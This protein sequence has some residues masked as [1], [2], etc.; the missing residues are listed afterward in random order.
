MMKRIFA[1]SAVA[2]LIVFGAYAQNIG[3]FKDR[4][5]GKVYKI[6]KIGSQV[7]MAENLNFAAE[8][9]KCYE[10]KNANCA[11][12]GRLYDDVLDALKACP[13]GFHLPDD[14]EWTALIDYA[15]GEKK[16]GKKLKS[17]SG[18]N[19]NGN[20]TDEYGFSAL[21][22]G[23]GRAGGKFDGIGYQGMWWSAT[24]QFGNELWSQGMNRSSESVD[25]IS[26]KAQLQSVRCVQDDLPK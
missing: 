20:G 14:E 4:R 6:V 8:G 21:P 17:T 7:W 19:D 22:G 13:A 26:T 10:N 1:V 3:T 12:Y 24:P 11:K 9:S 2:F 16:A 23:F 5:D 15:G 25:R 18:W